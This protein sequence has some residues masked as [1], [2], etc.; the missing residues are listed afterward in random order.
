MLW[1]KANAKHQWMEGGGLG[2]WEH[3]A[4]W[5]GVTKLYKHIQLW[6]HKPQVILLKTHTV[7]VILWGISEPE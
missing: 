2:T 5:M 6:L 4:A 7:L 1:N 3:S